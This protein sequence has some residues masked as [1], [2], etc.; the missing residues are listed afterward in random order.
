MLHLARVSKEYK[1]LVKIEIPNQ[2]IQV[3]SDFKQK[4]YNVSDF[5]WTVLQHVRF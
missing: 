5:K 4:F 3:L 2:K 1:M